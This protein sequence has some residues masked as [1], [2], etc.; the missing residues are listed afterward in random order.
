M[1]RVDSRLHLVAPQ[2]LASSCKAQHVLVRARFLRAGC[3]YSRHHMVLS[4]AALSYRPT[5]EPKKRRHETACAWWCECIQHR[6]L[7]S[8]KKGEKLFQAG[9]FYIFEN[10]CVLRFLQ[11]NDPQTSYQAFPCRSQPAFL[12]ARFL[13]RCPVSYTYSNSPAVILAGLVRGTVNFTVDYA[14][15]RRSRGCQLCA[16]CEYIH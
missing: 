10:G 7:I 6:T 11:Y 9:F 8:D 3:S 13:Y 14:T 12:I 4:A 2:N 5:Y 15:E 16:R 1:E